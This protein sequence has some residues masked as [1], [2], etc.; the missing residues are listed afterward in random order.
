MILKT[1]GCPDTFV[2]EVPI[3]G[4]SSKRTESSTSSARN[5][6]VS[7]V[8]DPSHHPKRPFKSISAEIGSIQPL[9]LNDAL[10]AR[11]LMPNTHHSRKRPASGLNGL[12]DDWDPIDNLET[13]G[14]SSSENPMEPD[15]ELL[16]PSPK[17][18]HE[19]KTPKEEPREEPIPVLVEELDES[20]L[21]LERERNL[22]DD[23]FRQ[24]IVPEK[25]K[26]DSHSST[27]NYVITCNY[28]N[29]GLQYNWRVKYGKLRLLDHALTHSSRMIP[30]KLCGYEC[31][32]VSRMRS[33]YGKIHP[34]EKMEGYGMKAL[35][36][37]NDG[38]SNQQVDEEELK[39]LWNICYKESIH[40]VGL[41]VGF[42]DGDKFR[43]M[44]KSRKIERAARKRIG[45]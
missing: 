41:A 25:P 30:C 3:I 31:T 11:A 20:E 22:I 39:G 23:L 21:A 26:E 5:D 38:D 14:A 4:H 29:C 44:T 40:L 33:H 7:P 34:D 19:L 6:S 16:E 42:G 18:G 1:I 10:E 45:C 28:P 37:G 2:T 43:R 13:P 8:S 9:D 17:A 36:S 12:F 15:L 27:L 35:V 24:Q 32:N